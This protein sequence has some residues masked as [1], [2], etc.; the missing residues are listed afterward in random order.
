[1]VA[2]NSLS[3]QI[4]SF[5]KENWEKLHRP[6]TGKKLLY[7]PLVAPNNLAPLTSLQQQAFAGIELNSVKNKGQPIIHTK[8]KCLAWEA[9][10]EFCNVLRKGEKPSADMTQIKLAIRVTE[11]EKVLI[12]HYFSIFLL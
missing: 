1:M 7:S 3:F 10:F 11:E 6:R 4:N 5:A 2:S 9:T 8:W 12:C